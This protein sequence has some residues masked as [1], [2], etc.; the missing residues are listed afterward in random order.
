MVA[1][2]SEDTCPVRWTGRQAV[3]TLPECIDVSN[4][5]CVREQLLLVINRGAA[6]LIVD[7]AAT[8]SCDYSGTDT[9][10]RAYQRAVA[11]GTDLRLVVVGDVVRRV[12]ALGGLDRLVSVYPTLEAAVA[13]GAERGEG[14]GEPGA[15]RADRTGELLDWVVN[16]IFNVGVSLQA[17]ADLPCDLTSQCITEALGRLDD[18]VRGIR[19]HVFAGYGER[20]QPGLA[21]RPPPE[22]GEHVARTASRTRLL[23][24][25]VAQTARA[26]QSAAADTAALLGQRA[27]LAGQPTG[28]DYRTDTKRW[29]VI[30]DQAAELAE[31][32]EQRPT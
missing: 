2:M 17:A 7:M 24:Q 14:S 19:D 8:V 23:H 18:V 6:V 15:D 22:P 32:W 1:V 31:R 5:D 4:A 29:R 26:V 9:L 27:D 30:A 16:S 20:A 3:V 21:W 11:N 25:R 28:E 13:A 12:L 10:M